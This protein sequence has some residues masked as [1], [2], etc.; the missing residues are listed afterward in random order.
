MRLYQ[1]P[2][3]FETYLESLER[4]L[5]ETTEEQKA[6]TLFMKLWKPLRDVMI[7]SSNGT[8][9]KT[10]GEMSKLVSTLFYVHFPPSKRKD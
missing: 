5:L 6:Q 9:P 4:H 3:V 8:L 2:G 1:D 10:R 7:M